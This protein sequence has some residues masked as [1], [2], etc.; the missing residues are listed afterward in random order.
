[1]RRFF[2][3]AIFFCI[4][5]TG[6]SAENLYRRFDNL[7]RKV[8]TAGLDT[9]YIAM[10]STSW[11]IPSCIGTH[12]HDYCFTAA[13]NSVVRD[14]PSGVYEYGIG[15]GYH[16]L[17]F[18]WKNEFRRDDN[19]GGKYFEFNFY[20]NYWGFQMVTS[21]WNRSGTAFSSETYGGYFA[22]NGNEFSYPAAVY[23]NYIQ[24][25]SAGSA[26]IFF[27]YDRN[28]AGDLLDIR[29]ASLCGGYGY[30]LVFRGGQTL[31]NFTAA[32]GVVAPYWGVSAQARLGFMH[33]FNDNLRIY[34]SAVQYARVGQRKSEGKMYGTEWMANVGVA[35]CFG[36]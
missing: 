32:A 24:R 35:F 6:A 21:S 20:D 31:F 30:N 36:K 19:P 14:N 15:I 28:R 16:G 34:G 5:C 27:W 12:G 11:E 22:F 2:S 10:T 4:F 8:M 9:S 25:K 23:G 7:V 29:D 17:D 18:I 13:D 1:M 3:A 26:M 33:W